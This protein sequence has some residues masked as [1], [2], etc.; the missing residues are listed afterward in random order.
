MTDRV[1]LFDM[2]GTLTDTNALHVVA[3][4]EAF[5]QA[6]HTVP[7][8]AI[9]RA[10]GLGATDLLERLLGP[11]RDTDRDE[12]LKSA[13]TVLYGTWFGRIPVLPGARDLLRELADRDW[14][15][16]V[17]TSAG[18]TELNA[19]LRALDADD[20]ITDIA[21]GAHVTRGKPHPEQVERALR[22]AS[23]PA[24]HAVFVGDSVWDMRAAARAEVTAIGLLSGGLPEADLVEAGAAEVYRDPAELLDSLDD[25]AFA[26][27]A[28]G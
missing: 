28:S 10:I 25:S 4:W 15:I 11:D 14:R 23:V 27:A 19:L 7:T 12:A 2:D 17:V 21:G 9:H 18:D 26:R 20:A 13:H 6:G 1:A 24:G 8:A 22:M 3:W 16:V 5:R